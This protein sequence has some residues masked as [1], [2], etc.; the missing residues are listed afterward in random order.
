MAFLAVLTKPKIESENTMLISLQVFL[1]LSGRWKVEARVAL[2]ADPNTH[3]CEI[4]RSTWCGYTLMKSI[5][6]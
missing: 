6:R 4:H 5:M 1:S 2:N 3:F